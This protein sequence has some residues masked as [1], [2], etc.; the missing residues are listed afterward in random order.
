M[1]SSELAEFVARVRRLFGGPME[2]ELFAIAKE[3]IAG[4]KAKPCEDALSEYA[5]MHGGARMRFI[6][7]KFFDFYLKRVDTAVTEARAE[8]IDHA[9][10]REIS[11]A[12]E[13]ERVRRQW[14]EIRERIS[15]MDPLE[16]S[17]IVSELRG[18]GWQ[19]P[20]A[21]VSDWPSLWLLAVDDIALDR[22]V[23]VR[24]PESGR[25]DLPLSA[26]EFYRER[27]PRPQDSSR[28]AVTARTAS[29]D[30]LSLGR[31]SAA[32]AGSPM[33]SGG[34]TGIDIEEIPF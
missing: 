34:S 6:P 20:P 8:R 30:S 16:R 13:A 11:D 22:V 33:A 15:A 1:T 17:A 32:P 9:A 18:F 4:L 23:F 29:E 31:P 2:E 28:E 7:A 21:A 27:V 25:W 10:R 26:V 3:R 5:L 24:D 12:M 14:L 19:G